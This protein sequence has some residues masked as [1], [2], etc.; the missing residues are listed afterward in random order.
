MD[1]RNF[2][3]NDRS[4][5]T[6]I[7]ITSTLLSQVGDN[8]TT[9]REETRSPAYVSEVVTLQVLCRIDK[10]RYTSFLIWA[11][12][13]FIRKTKAGEEYQQNQ[14]SISEALKGYGI[15]VGY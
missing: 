12:K 15:S 13:S 9:V 5:F 3:T 8:R 11:S 10:I 4:E 6:S 1:R 2:V 7:Y 14:K